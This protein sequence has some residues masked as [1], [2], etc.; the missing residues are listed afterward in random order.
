ML[1]CRDRPRSA[2]H[3][4]RCSAEWQRDFSRP[5]RPPYVTHVPLAESFTASE[6]TWPLVKSELT[7]TCSYNCGVT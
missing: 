5:G 2:N 3:V 4:I 6:A 1:R 7:A